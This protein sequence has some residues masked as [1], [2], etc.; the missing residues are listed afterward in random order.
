ML[1]FPPLS[2]LPRRA[3]FRPCHRRRRHCGGGG[4]RRRVRPWL[5]RI[6]SHSAPT[7]PR[8]HNF[9]SPSSWVASRH[10]TGPD[11]GP[12]VGWRLFSLHVYTVLHSAYPPASTRATPVVG[13]YDASKNQES[14]MLSYNER[15]D[16]QA[17]LGRM[18]EGPVICPGSQKY[19]SSWLR[20]HP[21][22][23]EI[24]GIWL[25]CMTRTYPVQTY[26]KRVGIVK[27]PTCPVSTLF[28][29]RTVWKQYLN[30][31]MCLP[32]IQ[33]STNVSPQPSASS[34]HLLPE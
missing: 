18:A 4:R 27:S 3:D 13:E 28:G 10:E 11:R 5:L 6:S 7:P 16:E 24:A 12:V 33:R 30:P 26:L 1:P 34:D 22:V 19:G 20:V 14:H 9:H 29:F 23:R 21:A 8:F 2:S 15:A 17:E 25:K 31:Y 32:E